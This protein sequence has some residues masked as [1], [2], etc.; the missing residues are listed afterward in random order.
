MSFKGRTQSLAFFFFLLEFPLQAALWIGDQGVCKQEGP[1]LAF[2]ESRL[3]PSL[4]V[5]P[6]HSSVTVVIER[7]WVVFLV[8]LPG[9]Q[10][11]I[12]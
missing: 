5:L 12:F 4:C 6:G 7:P 1:T 2:C 3:V 10:L 11:P 8:G 9:W